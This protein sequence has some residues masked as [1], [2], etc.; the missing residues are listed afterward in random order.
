MP[1]S[2]TY[3]EEME[4]I[5]IPKLPGVMLSG[6]RHSIAACYDRNSILRLGSVSTSSMMVL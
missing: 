4:T 1:R 3:S 6:A 5:D 2:H